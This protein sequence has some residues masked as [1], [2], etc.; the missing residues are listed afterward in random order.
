MKGWNTVLGLECERMD[1]S[2]GAG[3]RNTAVR[4]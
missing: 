2:I 3:E 1:H 4:L